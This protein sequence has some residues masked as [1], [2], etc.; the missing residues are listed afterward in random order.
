MDRPAVLAVTKAVS[1]PVNAAV[2]EQQP[3]GPALETPLFSDETSFAVSVR[4]SA[5]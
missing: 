4:A 1:S 2:C 3:A 5:S